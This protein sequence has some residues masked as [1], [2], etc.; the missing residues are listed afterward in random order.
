MPFQEIIG[1]PYYEVFPR[2]DNPLKTCLKAHKLQEV[3]LPSMDKIFKTRFYSIK[4][5]DGKTLYFI[6]ILEDITERKRSE[7]RYKLIIQTAMDG[8]WISD[9]QGRILDVNDAY[10]KLT[11][12]SRDEMLT[13]ISHR[14]WF[15]P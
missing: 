11:G 7:E 6:H 12:Y 3:S 9:T 5:V 1:K 2:M 4:D 13:R 14:S 15:K 10:C 8:F